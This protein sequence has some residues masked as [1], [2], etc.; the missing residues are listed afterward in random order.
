LKYRRRDGT[1]RKIVGIFGAAAGDG[2]AGSDSSVERSAI[3]TADGSGDGQCAVSEIVVWVR[4]CA[5]G[6]KK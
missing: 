5:G 2:R 4:K 3:L 1:V 6:G